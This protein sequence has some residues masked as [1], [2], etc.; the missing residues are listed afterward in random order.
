MVNYVRQ[1]WGVTVPVQ[2]MSY[3]AIANDLAARIAAGEPGYRADDRLPSIGEL[4]D[5]Y[6]VGRSTAA[7]AVRL[8]HDRGLIYGVAG[9][10]TYVAAKQS[11]SG[12]SA[13]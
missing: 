13:T 7:S 10:G 3:R 8:L 2:R 4:A 11:P 1:L 12:G 5:M 6:G 9:V